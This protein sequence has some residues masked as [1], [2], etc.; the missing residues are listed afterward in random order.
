MRTRKRAF[1]NPRIVIGVITTAISLAATHRCE[2]LI[3]GGFGNDPVHDAGWPNGSLE[4]A[5]LQSR[6]G[7]WEGPPFGGGRYVY[8]YREKDTAAFNKALAKFAQIKSRK[9]ELV[10]HDGPHESFWLQ[11]HQKPP[12]EAQPQARVDWTFTVWRP[13]SWHRLYNDPRTTFASDQREFRRPVDPPRVDLYVGLGNIDF[14]QVELPDS[15]TVRD[16]R[17]SAAADQADA[18]SAFAGRVTDIRTGKPIAGAAVEAVRSVARPQGGY[19]V[20]KVASAVTDGDGNYRLDNLDAGV[21]ALNIRADGFASRA[22]SLG[23]DEQPAYRPIDVELSPQAAILGRVLDDQGEPLAGVIVSTTTALAID[24]RGYAGAAYR[25]AET[26]REGRF[27]LRDLP[28][29][30]AQLSYRKE[31]YYHTPLGELLAVPGE[32]IEIRMVRTGTIRGRLTE[33]GKPLAGSAVSLNQEGKTPDT[34]GGI[35]TWGGG[36]NTDAEGRFEFA[37]APPG[38]YRIEAGGQTKIVTLRGGSVEVEIEK[39]ETEEEK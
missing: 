18:A 20:E 31:R 13:E 32:P 5:N 39:T 34:W 27:E 2:A 11:D 33:G 36:M 37:G 23:H 10:V 30:F 6:V 22:V 35:G 12:G 28:M 15:V 29:G 7:W 24:G 26:D 25:K 1:F 9:L 19:E 17:R 16:E 38:R 3:T 8:L 14:A 21:L 4:V